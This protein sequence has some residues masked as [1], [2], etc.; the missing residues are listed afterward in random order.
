MGYWEVLVEATEGREGSL[1][2]GGGPSNIRKKLE[3]GHV[4]C[5]SRRVG[6]H[7]LDIH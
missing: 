6:D 7:F 3:G 4:A 2:G 1:R 5:S